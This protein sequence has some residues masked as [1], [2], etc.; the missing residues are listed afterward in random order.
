MANEITFFTKENLKCP[1]CKGIV[2][3]EILRQGR[4]RLNAGDLKEDLRR[5]YVPSKKYGKIYPLI[6]TI[7]VCPQCWFAASKEDFVN[8][9]YYYEEINDFQ[10][11]RKEQV[12]LL[13][14]V[15]NI[16]F[17]QSRDLKSGCLSFF[18]ALH[19]YNFLKREKVIDFYKGLCAL[20][21][22]WCISD[23]FDKEQD[24]DFSYLSFYFRYLASISYEAFLTGMG[25]SHI[26]EVAFFGPDIDHDFGYK[27][28]IYMN[29]LLSY[30][31]IDLIKEDKAKHEKII[32]LKRKVSHIFG[33]GKKSKKSPSL[34]LEK[35]YLIYGK[36]KDKSK[37]LS[38]SSNILDSNNI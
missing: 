24:K 11:Q 31:F 18:L 22:S 8:S 14:K 32:K 6:Y 35:V 16:D 21:A 19:C 26:E 20:R 4:G 13:M 9:S 34:F 28:M 5:D 12:L 25:N 15:D 10:Q 27:G 29:S 2:K 1:I 23:L 30:E 36:I 37:Q 7:I 33:I 3:E 17:N 38:V